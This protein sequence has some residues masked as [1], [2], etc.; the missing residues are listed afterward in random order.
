MQTCI[1][2]EFWFFNFLYLIGTVFNLIFK[3]DHHKM[4]QRH[5]FFNN[6][7]SPDFDLQQNKLNKELRTSHVFRPESISIPGYHLAL[8]DVNHLLH[9]FFFA[10]VASTDDIIRRSLYAKEIRDGAVR[11]QTP[12]LK[13]NGFKLHVVKSNLKH[14]SR[15]RQGALLHHG[16]T[17]Q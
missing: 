5:L 17:L 2:S 12:F 9:K 16:Q 1:G 3:R 14:I 8:N 6:I 4:E 13:S 15:C 10:N 11:M 7:Q